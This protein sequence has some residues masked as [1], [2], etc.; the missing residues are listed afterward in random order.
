MCWVGMCMH[1]QAILSEMGL[2]CVPEAAILSLRDTVEQTL[3]TRMGN[4]QLEITKVK[5]PAIF[6]LRPRVWVASSAHVSV[7]LSQC[8]SR[9]DAAIERVFTALWRIK[10]LKLNGIKTFNMFN[11]KRCEHKV[12]YLVSLL[13]RLFFFFC[14]VCVSYA[15]RCHCHAVP[16][17][18][19]SHRDS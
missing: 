10:K 17:C 7:S 11:N 18:L 8:R 2:T 4:L 14:V 19:V 12:G 9:C 3:S 1:V 16:P 6:P 15:G 5:N 13:S